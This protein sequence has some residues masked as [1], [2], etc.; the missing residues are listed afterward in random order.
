MWLFE[1]DK[2]PRRY[3]V[4]YID[5][6]SQNDFRGFVSPYPETFSLQEAEAKVH[7]LNGGAS[8]AVGD[9]Q[10]S[11]ADRFPKL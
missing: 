8:G 7:F 1:K 9:L 4:G 6:D 3:R 2:E 11:F 5:N 10:D